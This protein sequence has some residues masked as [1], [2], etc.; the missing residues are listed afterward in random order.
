MSQDGLTQSPGGEWCA[1]PVLLRAIV[2]AERLD[3][4]PGWLPATSSFMLTAV[5]LHEYPGL[6]R[7]R[8]YDVMGWDGELDRR[9]R[10]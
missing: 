7:F 4:V 9:D 2:H 5:A 1:P 6:V 10:P 3:V 8:V